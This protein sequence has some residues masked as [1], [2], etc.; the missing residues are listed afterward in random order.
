MRLTPDNNDSAIDSPAAR[1]ERG[2]SLQQHFFSQLDHCPGL[3]R[4]I[5]TVTETAH[6]F[7]SYH[8]DKGVAPADLVPAYGKC[9]QAWALFNSWVPS[10][11]EISKEVL[12]AQQVTLFP[13]SE[14]W[15]RLTSS[16]PEFG[17][18]TS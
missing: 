2:V 9:L 11:S 15:S 3:L 16:A 4:F 1:V 5:N 7:C 8:N 14:T 10:G 12:F 17:T 18:T 6:T 13:P